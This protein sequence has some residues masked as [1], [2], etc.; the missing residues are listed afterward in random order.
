MTTL[1][2]LQFG[3]IPEMIDGLQWNDC[4]EIKVMIDNEETTFI[5]F[6]FPEVNEEPLARYAG[7]WFNKKEK[8]FEYYTYEVGFEGK[9]VLGSKNTIM[10]INLGDS[11]DGSI[12]GFLNLVT[13]HKNRLERAH[14]LFP[15]ED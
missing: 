1:Y 7:I 12:E 8:S 14:K 13:E 4:S 5:V 15:S 10:H 3:I 6:I 9:F 2:H 11:E